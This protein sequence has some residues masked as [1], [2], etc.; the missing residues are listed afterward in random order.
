M[1]AMLTYLAASKTV[2]F[3]I[4]GVE[5]Y[6]GV[7]IVSSHHE[8]IRQFIVEKMHTGV[9]IYQGLRGHGKRGDL[10]HTEIMF[11]VITRLEIARLQ[12]EVEKIDANAFVVMGT[13]HNIRGGIVRKRAVDKH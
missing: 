1:Y 6:I 7:T 12:H 5:E 4:D 8:E 9:T 13:V 2:D 3:I 10:H 11:T